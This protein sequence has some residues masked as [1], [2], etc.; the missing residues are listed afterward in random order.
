MLVSG[1]HILHD[2]LGDHEESWA[3]QLKGYELDVTE[4]GLGFND[5]IIEIY[6]DH[7]MEAI[8]KNSGNV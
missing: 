2:V 7:L 6:G 4:K 1:E 5:K 3:A 8:Q